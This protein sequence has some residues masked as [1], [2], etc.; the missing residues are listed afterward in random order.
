MNAPETRPS[1]L[2]RVRDPKDHEAWEEFAEIYRPVIC[3]MARIKGLQQAD[4]EDL[5]QQVLIA[6]SGAISRWVPDPGRAKFRTWLRRICENAVLNAL[7]RGVPDKGSGDDDMRAFL[8]QRAARSGP[9]S[10]LLKTE[11][12]REV[13]LQAAEKIRHEFSDDTWNSFWRTAVEG[14]SVEDAALELG[15]SRGSVYASRSR[16]MKRLRQKVEEHISDNSQEEQQE[17]K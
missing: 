17:G 13:F 1:L 11:F 7:T 16:V 2:L 9:D 5:S 8:E 14:L 12:R 3:R 10:D 15:R 6:V 4:A